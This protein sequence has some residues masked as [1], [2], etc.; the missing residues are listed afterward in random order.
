[1]PDQTRVGRR[2]ESDARYSAEPYLPTTPWSA[3]KGARPLRAA[4]ALSAVWP[5]R[6][7]DYFVPIR[8]AA[9]WT[10]AVALVALYFWQ[11][12]VTTPHLSTFSAD[13]LSY[14]QKEPQRAA[15]VYYFSRLV[16]SA[17]N[18]L[19]AIAAVQGLLLGAVGLLLAYSIRQSTGS[20]LLA[21]AALIVCLFKVS[22][23]FLTQDLASDSL[24]STGC[25]GL[26]AAA[27]LLCERAS[28]ARIVLFLLFAFSTSIVRSVGAAILWPMVFALA[29]R[30]WATQRRALAAV[31]AGCIGIYGVTATIAFINYGV[32]SPQSQAGFAMICGAPFIAD[33]SVPP[34]VPYPHKF[35]GATVKARDEYETASTWKA[36]FE[37]IDR[38]SCSEPIQIASSTLIDRDSDVNNLPCFRRI[39]ARND[40]FKRAALAVMLHN[41]LGY[42][43][44]TLV[45]FVAGVRMLSS[46]NN[47]PLQGVFTQQEADNRI[48]QVE[49]F[50]TQYSQPDQNDCNRPDLLLPLMMRY[51]VVWRTTPIELKSDIARPLRNLFDLVNF[52]TVNWLFIGESAIVFVLVTIA[53][54]RGRPISDFSN[55]AIYRCH[56][57]LC[58]HRPH[59]RNLGADLGVS[60]AALARGQKCSPRTGRGSIITWRSQRRRNSAAACAAS[61]DSPIRN[62]QPRWTQ[63]QRRHYDRIATA[64]TAN[65]GYPHTQEY[66]AYL[67][68]AV[69]EA[70][71]PG[72]LGT[73]AELCCG[74]AEA[75]NVFAGRITRYIGVDV[76]EQM[77]AAAQGMHSAAQALFVQ[78]DGTC[79][80][81]APA[82]IDT[83]VM[84][85]GIHHVPARDRLFKEIARILKPGGRLIYREPAND[86]VLW[87]ALRAVVYRLSPMLN[88]ATEHPLRYQDTVPA[89]ERAGLRSL[90]YRTHGLFGF[91]VFMNSDVLFFNRAFRF[92]PGIRAITRASARLDE[93][94]LALPG[95]ERAGLQVIGV[96]QKS[97][98]A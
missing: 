41:P 72:E 70:I 97:V 96:A 77:L 98:A 5:I 33:E 91:C 13:T 15:G 76:S 53:L 56:K 74:H 93:A 84:L 52:A 22:L 14:M 59:R 4:M 32:W 23:V 83:V 80:P 42:L 24:F 25:L 90:L 78:G 49:E 27:L 55:A 30:L 54:L 6:Y 82:S 44:M 16:L 37:L 68:R 21:L 71:G 92:V 48:A 62:D 79:T 51:V 40:T 46:G 18:D 69:H 26:L 57:P 20:A 39:I 67:D 87:R 95:L 12:F 88:S 36:K 61:L 58:L 11:I 2:V 28:P 73:V 3:L 60:G 94:L 50:I 86:F 89:L 65:L 75:L 64:Y 29:L 63:A 38:Y 47:Y 66:S 81:L 1:M 45:K 31:V 34:D 9:F 10:A 7:R 17:W 43:K 85:G 35:A 19:Y 8:R